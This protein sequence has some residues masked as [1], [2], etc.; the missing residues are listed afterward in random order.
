MTAAH[1]PH[2]L[3]YT[4][5][6]NGQNPTS[7]YGLHYEPYDGYTYVGSYY[8]DVC[9]TFVLYCLGIHAHYYINVMRYYLPK[10]GILEPVYGNTAADVELM[11]ILWEPGH[12]SIIS[13]IYRNDRGEVKKLYLSEDSGLIV[14]NLF[15]TEG[16]QE[17][18]NRNGGILFRYKYLY[19]NLDYKPSVYSPV[20]DEEL[21]Q[22]YYNNDICTFAG[23]KASFVTGNIIYLNYNKGDYA[24]IEIFDISETL[25]NTLHLDSDASIHRCD[26]TS[27]NLTYGT[28]K[29]RLTDGVN[30][31]DY[32]YFEILDTSVSYEKV[33]DKHKFYFSSQN[34]T[35]DWLAVCV[36]NGEI[37]AVVQLND[38]DRNNGYV[39]FNLKELSLEE[40]LTGPNSYHRW[41][42][43]DLDLYVRVYFEGEYGTPS[44]DLL[45]IEL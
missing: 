12:C 41:N 23:D 43:E 9:N 26:L 15:S 34:S 30:S 19:Q 29:A 11:D 31:S 18:M 8:G 35:P 10:I 4:E 37:V 22:P 27:L 39:M 1:N 2:S 44:S 28:Y 45:S 42:I 25:I 21:P 7:D 24:D 17:R 38:E 5:N 6:L 40:Y 16:L 13:D 33:G 36:T 20:E 14:S 32:T 3:L